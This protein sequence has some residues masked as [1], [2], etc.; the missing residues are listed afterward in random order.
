MYRYAPSSFVAAGGRRAADT[1]PPLNEETVRKTLRIAWQLISA[2]FADHA[3][4]SPALPLPLSLL[5]FPFPAC[6]KDLHFQHGPDVNNK[7]RDSKKDVICIL[8]LKITCTESVR[9]YLK[10]YRTTLHRNQSLAPPPISSLV[11]PCMV[12]D[13]KEREKRK[14]SRKTRQIGPAKVVRGMAARR[15]SCPA[16]GTL[17]MLVVE[18]KNSRTKIEST[19]ARRDEGKNGPNPSKPVQFSK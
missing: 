4:R 10:N 11:L 6:N 18:T 7:N 8:L 13:E 14:R 5:L 1:P 3:A 16:G 15:E 9:N 17:Y 12:R 2:F 19:H